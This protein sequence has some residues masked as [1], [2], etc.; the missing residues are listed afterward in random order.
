MSSQRLINRLA[1]LTIVPAGTA[2]GAIAGLTVS[3]APLADCLA[4]AAV[5][6]AGMLL[7]CVVIVALQGAGALGPADPSGLVSLVFMLATRASSVASELEDRRPSAASA[8]DEPRA[9]ARGVR[10]LEGGR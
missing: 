2:A 9:P 7:V 6:G 3:G 10:Q 5:A 4:T 8:E 1:S